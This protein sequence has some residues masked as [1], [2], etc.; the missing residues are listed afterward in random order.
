[1]EG[2]YSKSVLQNGVRVITEKIPDVRSV[3]VGIWVAAGSRDEDRDEAGIS[4]FIEHMVFKGTE[5]YSSLDIAKIFDQM[6]GI[7][8]AFTSKEITCFHV[9]VL[10]NHMD[11][12][13]GL[14][15]DMFLHS[16][17]DPVEIEKE[18]QV[19]LQEIGMVEDSPDDLIHD[20]FCEAYWPDHGLGR[21]I[22]GTRETVSAFDSDSIRRYMSKVYKGSKVIVAAAGDVD[23]EAF[24]DRINGLF[25]VLADGNGVVA[26]SAPLPKA[27]IRF[28]RKELEQAHILFGFKG[29]SVT[30]KWRFTAMLFNVILGGSMGSRLFQ[31]VR[32]KR[33]LAYS[34]YSFLSSYE[35]AGLL[36][37]YAAVAPDN[38]SAVAEIIRG[39]IMKL[40]TCPLLIEELD[41][42]R[43]HLKSE[44][45]L[46]S[47]STDVRMARLAKNEIAY[48]RQV[49][50]DEVVDNIEAVSSEDIIAFA[51]ACLSGDAS[52]V[53]LGPV[54]DAEVHR[55]AG[56]I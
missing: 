9:K 15:S 48:G 33:G 26:R 14:L 5:R 19:V 8:N 38:V 25:D 21:S 46:L 36:G 11:K 37:T 4:H 45:L 28:V 52:L 54:S 10:K 50:Y 18:C 41:A 44:L 42:A 20:L 49:S 12:A 31:E 34:V 39:E 40:A 55:C 1:M 56:L 22:L 53:C 30:D 13:V 7:S 6:G 32:E 43:D 23:H 2:L 29:P 51:D 24:R 27:G 17:F 16:V 47:E 35:D 3:S